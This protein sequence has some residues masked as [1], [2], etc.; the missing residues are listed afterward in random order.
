MNDEASATAKP[1]QPTVLLTT[2]NQERMINAVPA[3]HIS[4][5]HTPEKEAFDVPNARPANP[6]L[7]PSGSLLLPVQTDA[8]ALAGL[9]LR[10]SYLLVIPI[11][12]RGYS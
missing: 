7:Y 9:Q 1:I 12:R 10:Y 8:L 4:P 3:H 11:L 5:K 6:N 2:L